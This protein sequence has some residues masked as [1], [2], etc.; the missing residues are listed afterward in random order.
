LPCGT[1]QQTEEDDKKELRMLNIWT[2]I[3]TRLLQHRK[4]D[5]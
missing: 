5:W 3:Q 1:I 4:H 2:G